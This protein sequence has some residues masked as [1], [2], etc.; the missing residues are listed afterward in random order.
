[1][2]VVGSPPFV[3]P[4]AVAPV[5]IL[6]LQK[7]FLLYPTSLG[8]YTQEVYF[9]EKSCLHWRRSPLMAFYCSEWKPLYSILRC[10]FKVLVYL[11]PYC[12]VHTIMSAVLFT[13]INFSSSFSVEKTENGEIAVRQI[14]ACIAVY[15]HVRAKW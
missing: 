6:Q 2:C 5:P 4:L 14:L 3:A 1:M 9:P 10:Y 8:C 15:L 13:A 7:N 12:N 11:L